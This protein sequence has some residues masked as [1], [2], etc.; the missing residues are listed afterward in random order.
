[1]T[2]KFQLEIEI[3]QT[4][5]SL[6]LFHCFLVTLDFTDLCVA[7]RY[8]TYTNLNTNP[9]ERNKRDSGGSEYSAIF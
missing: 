8:K 3:I 2:G 4:R 1:M 6:N 5:E 7:K 9:E